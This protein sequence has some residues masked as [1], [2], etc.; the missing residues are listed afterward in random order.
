VWPTLFGISAIATLARSAWT[1][2]V[3]G[4]TLLHFACSQGHPEIVELFLENGA[5]VTDTDTDGN[6]ALHIVCVN[7]RPEI[8]RV[9]LEN[10]D[11][12]PLENKL[13]IIDAKNDFGFAPLH[14]ASLNSHP[15]I[16]TLLIE[17]GADI[18]ILDNEEGK[19][20]LNLSDAVS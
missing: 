1:I 10:I 3:P 17:F 14:L 18:E 5:K 15:E 4:N 12:L 11:E 19:T 16:I 9:L 13:A 7:N 6:T 8:A 20:P 2:S